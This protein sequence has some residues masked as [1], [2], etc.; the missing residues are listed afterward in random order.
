MGKLIGLTG[1]KGLSLRTHETRSSLKLNH[2]EAK[3]P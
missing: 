1:T 2:P 3:P